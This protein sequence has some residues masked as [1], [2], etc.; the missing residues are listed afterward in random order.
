MGWRGSAPPAPVP[1]FKLRLEQEGVLLLPDLVA[2]V[3]NDV[4]GE[5]SHGGSLRGP[6]HGLQVTGI[7]SPMKRR[8]P[9]RDPTR[10]SVDVVHRD[11]REQVRTSYRRDATATRSDKAGGGE[12]RYGR[13]QEGH[14]THTATTTTRD[15]HPAESHPTGG[16]THPATRRD[17][18]PQRQEG[19]PTPGATHHTTRDTPPGEG[20][21]TREPNPHRRGTPDRRTRQEGRAGRTTSRGPEPPP[22]PPYVGKITCSSWF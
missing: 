4:E 18:Q 1:H 13:G 15:T 10:G 12:S 6:C 8:A 17:T 21:P 20:H 11:R 2:D 22:E 3:A 9:R 19:H 14:P 7:D 5:A 16:A